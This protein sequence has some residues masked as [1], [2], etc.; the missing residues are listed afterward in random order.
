MESMGELAVRASAG[1]AHS[2]QSGR[3]R[4]LK[5]AGRHDVAQRCPPEGAGA[6]ARAV[7]FAP[8]GKRDSPMVVIAVNVALHLARAVSPKG[9]GQEQ[10]RSA[11]TGRRHIPGSPLRARPRAS[12]FHSRVRRTCSCQRC[13][14][15]ASWSCSAGGQATSWTADPRSS[16]GH[17]PAQIGRAWKRDVEGGGARVNV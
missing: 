16:A 8:Q 17:P 5:A 4:T 3:A 7:H 6:G 15:E 10:P 11:H 14:S 9:L 2:S 13:W 1:V 12:F